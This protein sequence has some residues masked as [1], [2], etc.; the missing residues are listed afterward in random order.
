MKLKLIYFK[1]YNKEVDKDKAYLAD[2]IGIYG[3]AKDPKDGERVNHI[4]YALSISK[5]KMKLKNILA[6]PYAIVILPITFVG[7]L[8]IAIGKLLS[9][10]G[11]LLVGDVDTAKSNLRDMLW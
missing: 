4:Y 11:Y 1:E 10:I 3:A 9:S 7:I 8:L 6:F 5:I 2:K